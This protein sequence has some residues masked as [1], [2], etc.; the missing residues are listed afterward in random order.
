MVEQ[1]SEYNIQSMQLGQEGISI[2]LKKVTVIL[3]VVYIPVMMDCHS[4]FARSIKG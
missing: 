4:H 3:K 2:T 1:K